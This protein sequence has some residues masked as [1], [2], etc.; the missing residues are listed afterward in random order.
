MTQQPEHPAIT[1]YEKTIGG[2]PDTFDHF[3]AK[4][5]RDYVDWSNVPL[6]E[7]D[8]K[9]NPYVRSFFTM[10]DTWHD[11]LDE[12]D[13]ELRGH[14]VAGGLPTDHALYLKQQALALFT[15]TT[16]LQR[17][18]LEYHYGVAG[19]AL[20]EDYGHAYVLSNSALS[21]FAPAAPTA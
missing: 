14:V 13:S 17:A 20:S 18:A 7:A 16:A 6:T 8:T 4:T 10:L 1:A 21:P 15:A 11:A 3:T 19:P 2:I 12:L 5:I 9:A